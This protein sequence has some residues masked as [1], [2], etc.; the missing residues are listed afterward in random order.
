MIVRQWFHAKNI[1]RC[2]PNLTAIQR[3]QKRVIVDQGTT[4]WIYN[5]RAFCE[6]IQALNV[7]HILSRGRVGQKQ[8]N[9]LCTV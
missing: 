8:D 6:P 4:P 5:H 3:T 1:Q 7:Q 2:V 9:D